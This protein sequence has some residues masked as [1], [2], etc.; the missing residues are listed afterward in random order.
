LGH[1]SRDVGLFPLE[2]AIWKMTGLTAETFGIDRRGAVREGY[3]ADLTVFDPAAVK[4]RAT[5]A[6]PVEPAQGIDAVIVN[7]HIAY[8]G[9]A[10]SDDRR[11]RVLQRRIGA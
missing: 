10:Y 1:Y 11:G 9:T 6:D 7:G 3:F 8:S 2:A 4:D 5:Y